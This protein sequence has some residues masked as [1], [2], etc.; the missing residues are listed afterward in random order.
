MST[1]RSDPAEERSRDRIDE[2]LS[3]AGD[4]LA[5]VGWQAFTMAAV[6]RRCD[7]SVR[8]LYRDFPDKLKLVEALIESH[9]ERWQRVLD[10]GADVDGGM[11]LEDV[12]VTVV[13]QYGA[14][15]RRTSGLFAVIRASRADL[16]ARRLFQRTLGPV[17]EWMIAALRRRLPEIESPRLE[18][19]TALLIEIMQSLMYSSDEPGF[20][21]RGDILRE[22]RLIMR[23]YLGELAHEG[24]R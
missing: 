20:P 23:G 3:A 5:E 18:E 4:E 11:P 9:T 21:E 15:V 16:E 17:R 13:E 6:A 10:T 1:Q 8:S 19:I 2:V 24:G 12:I 7:R 22:A 14:D